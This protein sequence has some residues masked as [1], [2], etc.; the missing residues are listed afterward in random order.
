[1]IAADVLAPVVTAQGDVLT[2][3]EVSDQLTVT[4]PLVTLVADGVTAEV[5]DHD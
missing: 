2:L 4:A 5:R 1:M 3:G